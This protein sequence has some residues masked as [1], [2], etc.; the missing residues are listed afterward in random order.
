MRIRYFAW[1]REKVGCESEDVELPT[2]IETVA[3]LVGWL[4]QR[5]PQY[6]EAFARPQV[7]RAALDKVHA[8]PTTAL[9]ATREIA[10]FPPV[11]GG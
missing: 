8:K 2:D 7:V 5:G 6:D 11:T 10:F 4:K 3:D 1:V 9:G